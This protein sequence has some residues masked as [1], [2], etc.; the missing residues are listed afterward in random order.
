MSGCSCSCRCGKSDD[1]DSLS[2]GGGDEAVPVGGLGVLGI[3]LAA[4]GVVVLVFMCKS[5]ITIRG[6]ER[7]ISG[8]CTEP[9]KIMNVYVGRSTLKSHSEV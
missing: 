2:L 9:E 8:N 4:G 6:R 5:G 3:G 7:G 1:P